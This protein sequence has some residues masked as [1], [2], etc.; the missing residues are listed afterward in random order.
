LLLPLFVTAVAIAEVRERTRSLWPGLAVHA[1]FNATTLAAV[2]SGATPEG[3]PPPIPLLPAAIGCAL[4]LA[5]IGAVRNE[6]R[7]Q[8]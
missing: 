7:R 8:R 6:S 2:F 3:K 1:A 4:V 5:L